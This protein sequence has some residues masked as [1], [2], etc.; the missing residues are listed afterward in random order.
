MGREKG[1]IMRSALQL[2]I[3][4]ERKLTFSL[5]L[6]QAVEILQ[7]PQQQLATWLQNEVEKN[8][9]LEIPE[10]VGAREIDDI[11]Y[12]PSLYENLCKE[13]RETFSSAWELKVAEVLIGS[14]DDRG[15]LATPLEEI[16]AFFQTR[17]EDIEP[18]LIKIHS[19]DP[20]GIGAR[21]LQE[22]LLI[23]L[24]RQKEKGS[25]AYQIVADHFEDLLQG[26][27]TQIKKNM[28]IA[29][30]EL[31][32]A[33]QKLAKLQLRP[34]AGFEKTSAP[35]A[36]ADLKAVKIDQEWQIE[37]VEDEFPLIQIRQDLPNLLPKLAAEEKKSVK[38]WLISA[39]WLLRS[40][41]R[42]N[43]LLISLTTHL[44]KKQGAYLERKGPL[45][46][47]GA[48]D[49]AELLA[50]HES[51]I[52]RA[53]SDKLLEGPWGLISLRS[54]LSQSAATE[55]HKQLLQ[56]LIEQENKCSPLTDEELSQL[57][58]KKGISIARRTIAKYRKELNVGSAA[59]R[60]QLHYTES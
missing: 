48:S 56:R 8:P 10:Q 43:R 35:T 17:L 19:F 45:Q 15:F 2:N 59:H 29:P 47:V 32:A 31:S 14:L 34:A 36:L 42:R 16:A 58:H 46:Q 38:H 9:L 50:V 39:K 18:I 25:L 51:T 28:Q 57:L 20:P 6:R 3:K 37:M 4:A 27:Y 52:H 7:M 1:V 23:Q 53:L 24:R 21:H 13:A 54:L 22:S 41:S 40:L 26:R 33:I 30:E 55:H 5:A 12:R 49:L 60:K 44:L 11:P